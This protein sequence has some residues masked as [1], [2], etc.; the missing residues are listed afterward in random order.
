MQC[1]THLKERGKNQTNK[2]I[3]PRLKAQKVTFENA[4][5][6]KILSCNGKNQSW[7]PITRCRR[8]LNLLSMMSRFN[9]QAMYINMNLLSMMLRF[10]PQAV[11]IK[12][13][14]PRDTK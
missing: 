4:L 12:N 2:R 13:Y 3:E 8:Y 7:L 14:L 10:N 5:F 11:Y 1:N 6:Y 9:P